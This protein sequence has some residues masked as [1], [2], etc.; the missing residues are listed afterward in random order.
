M[1]HTLAGGN[2]SIMTRG[3]DTSDLSMIHNSHWYPGRAVMA[4]LANIRRID[5]R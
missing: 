1:R 4:G 3:A 5:M 2:Y